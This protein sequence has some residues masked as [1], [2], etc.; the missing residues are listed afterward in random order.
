MLGDWF[1][2][3][4]GPEALAALAKVAE[5]LGRG[6]T[7]S[8]PEAARVSRPLKARRSIWQIYAHGLATLIRARATGCWQARC[9]LP[10]C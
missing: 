5:A 4:A 9:C 1:Q 8:L 6:P 3:G 10:L 2:D 7:V